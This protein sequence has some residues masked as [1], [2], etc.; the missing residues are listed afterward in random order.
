MNPISRAEQ[1]KTL[2]PHEPAFRIQQIE[3]AL[4][5]EKINGWLETTTLPKAIRET[6][7]KNVPWITCVEAKVFQS[8]R[9]D[10]FK[11]LL[12]TSDN[13]LFESVLMANKRGQWT[14]CVS[15]Q[16]GCAMKCVFCAT[17]TMGLKRSLLAD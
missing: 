2:F 16:I 1:F 7:D 17:G 11:A 3:K 14:I 4:F 13:H 5:D 8:S 15:S 12:K 10:T 9:K 6:L